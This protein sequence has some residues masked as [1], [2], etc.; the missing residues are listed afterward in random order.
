MRTFKYIL[1][2][3]GVT[4]LAADVSWRV[5][6]WHH[7]PVYRAL[8]TRFKLET[9]HTND[10]SGIGIFYAK[11]KEPLWTEFEFTNAGNSSMESYYFRG[12]DVFDITLSSNRPPRYGVYVRGPDKSVTWWLDDAGLG[13]FTERIYYNTNGDFYKREIWYKQ[14]WHLVDRRDGKNGLVIDGQWHQL[15]FDTNK[16]WTIET[17]STNRF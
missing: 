17:T 16:A 15:A 14:A 11:T 9:L 13:S 2:I 6:A 10:A 3:A 12:H 5:W 4:L 1:L 7:F 8:A